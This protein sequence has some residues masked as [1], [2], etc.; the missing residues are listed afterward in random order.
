MQP[1]IPVE[2]DRR[3]PRWSSRIPVRY[4]VFDNSSGRLE[5]GRLDLS[6][7]YDIGPRG[8]LLAR[9]EAPVGTRL[10]FF[11]ELPESWGNVIEAFGVVVHNQARVD[12]LGYSVPGSGVR[13]LHISPRDRQRLDRYLAERRAIDAA[14]LSAA[15]VRA[16]AEALL[17]RHRN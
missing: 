17:P 9:V 3:E 8:L 4:H 13:L 6:R 1:L 14:M 5:L 15:A 16:R 11:F 10:H 7:A 2:N 12:P